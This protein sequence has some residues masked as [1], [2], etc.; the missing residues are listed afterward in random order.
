MCIIKLILKPMIL[1]TITVKHENYN[2]KH[3]LC[4]ESHLQ[5]SSLT[6]SNRI[7]MFHWDLTGLYVYTCWGELQDFLVDMHRSLP[8]NYSRCGF[9]PLVPI[10]P[11]PELWNSIWPSTAFW[12]LFWPSIIC[13]GEVWAF[14]SFLLNNLPVKAQQYLRYGYAARLNN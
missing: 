8:A 7:D 5:Y 4:V 13:S 6:H 11:D 2:G 10:F 12:I 9:P 1:G 3:S 14:L